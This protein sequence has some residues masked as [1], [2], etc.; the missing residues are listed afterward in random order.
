MSRITPQQRERV[1]HLIT[2][3]AGLN[4]PYVIMNFLAAVIA[5]YGLLIN[6]PATVIAAMVIAMLLGPLMG[7]ALALMHNNPR[8]LRRSVLALGAGALIIFA[9][10]VLIGLMNRDVQITDAVTGLTEPSLFSLIIALAGGAAGAYATA[11]PKLV[12]GFVGVALAT[13][14]VPPL[15]AAGL[16][17]ARAE[18]LMAFDALFLAFINIVAIQF[19]MSAVLWFTGFRHVTRKEGATIKTFVLRNT[20]SIGLLIILAVALTFNLRTV[21]EQ[22][23]F[24]SEVRSTLQEQVAKLAGDEVDTVSFDS[25]D[26]KTIVLAQVFGP[27]FE[28]P[29]QQVTNIASKLPS[30]SN[31]RNVDLRIRYIHVQA[32]DKNGD[33]YPD[34]ESLRDDNES[35]PDST[36]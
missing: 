24:R 3:R 25:K 28:I 29:P 21:L 18:W 26:D 19:A 23:A 2:E 20:L 36:D 30:D 14:L 34:F 17:I 4:W 1:T 10:A 5:S 9:V 12:G 7:V 22:Q 8:L 6:S 16:L 33:I 32:T 15:A 11:S 27:R 31:G 13:S 35:L